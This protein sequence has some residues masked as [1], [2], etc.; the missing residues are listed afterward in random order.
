MTAQPYVDTSALA[1]YYISEA[2]S[3]DFEAYIRTTVSAWISQLTLVEFRCLLARRRRSGSL[4][5]TQETGTM[6]LFVRHVSQN[7]WL[8]QRV[9]DPDYADAARLIDHL[10]AI[11]LRTLDAI[12]LSAA[13]KS[14]TA[15]IATA[16][17]TMAA[18]ASASG[19]KPVFF[20]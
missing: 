18:A 1:K 14:G 19:L 13:I 16:D 15:E 4:S 17:R 11:P 9:D 3:T 8:I 20:G 2:G 6:A 7:L 10:P 12:H 5:A